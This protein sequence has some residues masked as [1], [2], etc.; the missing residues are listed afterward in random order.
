MP[1]DEQLLQDIAIE[2]GVDPAFIEKDWYAIQVLA[3]IAG[4]EPEQIAPVFCGGTCLSKAHGL[5]K[6]FS[7]DL[8]FRGHFQSGKA[9]SKPVRR[10]FRESVLSAVEAVEGV[11]LDRDQVE[12]GSSY[13]KFQL[14]YQRVF[15]A[16]G[17]LRPHLQVEFSYTQ[18]KG[19]TETRSVQSFVAEFSGAMPEAEIPCLLPL[20]T[21]ADKLCA[22]TWRVI[23]R[24][25]TH[26]SDDPALIRHL[27]DLGALHPAILSGKEL[28]AETARAAYSIDMQSGPRKMEH[29]LPTAARHALEILRSD[30]EYA[31][32]YQQFV[33]NMSYAKDD[34]VIDFP[35]AMSRLEDIVSV[36]V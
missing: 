10:R 7:E 18:P 26:E 25:R 12:S 30:A 19:N 22:L 16:P 9:P 31:V 27:H 32:E 5:L 1:P 29:D 24:D 36:V 17:G 35:A 8:D 4:I 13:F 20:E 3:A 21:A 11:A 33:M 15:D 28:F 2:L 6:R 23:K 34:E 14:R